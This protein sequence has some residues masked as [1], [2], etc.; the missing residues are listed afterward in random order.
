MRKKEKDNYVNKILEPV[1]NKMGFYKIVYNEVDGSSWEFVRIKD[2][3]EQIIEILNG[4]S[5][6][7]RFRTNIC[8]QRTVST[9]EIWKGN[10]KWDEFGIYPY[11]DNK[12][13]E[14]ILNFYARLI[15]EKAEEVFVSLSVRIIPEICLEDYDYLKKLC[16]ERKENSPVELSI[17]QEKMKKLSDQKIENIKYDLLDLS[18]EYGNWIIANFGGQWGNHKEEFG[19]IKVGPENT[20]G[21]VIH[22]IY[23][24]WKRLL[25]FEENAIKNLYS[26]PYEDEFSI[27]AITDED[28]QYLKELCKSRKTDSPATFEEV[29]ER[30]DVLKGEDFK[31]IKNK[32]LMIAVDYGNRLIADYGGEWNKI[33]GGYGID[34]V[35]REKQYIDVICDIYSSWKIPF[36][37]IN[38]E[39]VEGQYLL[40]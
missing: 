27:P 36:L 25:S 7:M 26:I 9:N 11:K 4:I 17:L 5:L 2:G 1:C 21:N 28:Y 3:V 6:Q 20:H 14:N 40:V 29:Q 30:I 34:K 15:A 35:G 33:E 10:T 38:R 18:F 23:I 13:F 31:A 24:F 22:Q 32:L 16:M 19:V 39:N 12:E 37:L 8:G